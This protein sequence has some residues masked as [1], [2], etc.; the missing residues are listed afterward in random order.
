MIISQSCIQAQGNRVK[1]EVR[2]TG[3]SKRRTRLD[4]A[5]PEMLIS[6]SFLLS[7]D[8]QFRFDI[9]LAVKVHIVVVLFGRWG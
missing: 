5:L 9:G 8:Y 3:K 4:F 6:T 7:C 1:R 2:T